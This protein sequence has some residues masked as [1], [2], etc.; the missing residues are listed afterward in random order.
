M[1]AIPFMQKLYRIHLQNKYDAMVKC[2]QNKIKRAIESTNE[3]KIKKKKKI[4][5]MRVKGYKKEHVKTT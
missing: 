5:M 4:Q 2:E 3:C 1:T